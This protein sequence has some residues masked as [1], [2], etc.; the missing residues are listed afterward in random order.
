MVL[1]DME[2]SMKTGITHASADSFH[3]G[4][5]EQRN[6]EEVTVGDGGGKSPASDEGKVPG[7][8]SGLSLHQLR[9]EIDNYADDLALAA[10]AY[11][12]AGGNPEE[13][14]TVEKCW[15][16]RR[17]RRCEWTDVEYALRER[18]CN[19]CREKRDE[20]LLDRA[21]TL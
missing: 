20:L 12:A 11:L 17:M 16:C 3:A 2:A 6:R 8:A 15:S 18:W 10:E 13:L 14:P 9:I 1:H 21:V 4:R 7:G 19:A 5:T